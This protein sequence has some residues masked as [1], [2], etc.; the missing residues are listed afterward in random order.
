MNNPIATAMLKNNS[1]NGLAGLSQLASIMKG[2]PN[3]VYEEMMKT[4]PK[5]AKFVKENEGKSPEQI[6]KEN[7]IDPSI[8]ELFKQQI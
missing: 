8:L 1:N 7:G 5:F 4:N 3:K 2:D 6:A